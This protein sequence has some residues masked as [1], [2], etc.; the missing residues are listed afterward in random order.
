MARLPSVLW[1][2]LSA[3]DFAALDMASVVAVQPIAAVEQHGP[4]LPVSVDATI[5]A[6][7]VAAAVAQMG[8]RPALVLPM[9]PIGKSNEHARF[10]GTLTLSYETLAR[11]W[12]EIGTSVRRGRLS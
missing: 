9:L 5:N 11:V 12:L 10:P 1:W 8:E 7:I 6:G 4:H 2:D 3:R